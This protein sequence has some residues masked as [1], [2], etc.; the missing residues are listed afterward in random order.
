MDIAVVL[1]TVTILGAAAQTPPVLGDNDAIGFDYLD[2]DFVQWQVTRFEN[3][4]DG[5]AWVTISPPVYSQTSGV[6]TYFVRPQDISTP[7]G[8]HTVTFRAC[9]T[10]GCSTGTAPFQFAIGSVT[11]PMSEWTRCATEGSFCGFSGTKEVR[12]GANGVF[13][14][15]T[16]T[17]GTPCTNEVFGDPVPGV[18]KACDY[19]DATTSPAPV[20]CVVS[21]WVF[22]SATAWGECI[23]G[24][25]TRTETWIR[26][27]T[28]QPANGGAS[29]PLLVEQRTGSQ[30]CEILPIVV[31]SKTANCRI[32]AEDTQG[33]PTAQTGWGVQFRFNNPDGS[34][35]NFG[36]RDASSPYRQTSGQKLPG[37]YSV[38]GV[39]SRVG[40]ASVVRGPVSITCQ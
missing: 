18:F 14:T 30:P 7:T 38:S 34:F 15:R 5:G 40:S 25:Q 9:N 31:S 11:P 1:L 19:R 10:Q 16:F 27:V 23:N 26:T 29:C 13:V 17:D 20:D 32:M 4:Y 8:T 39:W 12:Y 36:N 28:T 6:T 3:Q 21:D 2:A 37:T 22:Q 35:T 24:V 33:P